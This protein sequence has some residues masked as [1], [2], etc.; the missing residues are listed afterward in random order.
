MREKRPLQRAMVDVLTRIERI[1]IRVA[2]I[3][4]EWPSQLT[5]RGSSYYVRVPR[6]FVQ[7]YELSSGD[8]LKVRVLEVKRLITE[9]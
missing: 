7:Y 4:S 3:S 5:I 8:W 2:K 6:D 1:R 9:E